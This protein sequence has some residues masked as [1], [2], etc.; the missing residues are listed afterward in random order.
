MTSIN[1]CKRPGF[2]HQAL[3]DEIAEGARGGAA[4]TRSSLP[5]TAR[6][7]MPCSAPAMATDGVAA[8]APAPAP[9]P[10]PAQQ[11]RPS[12]SA[13]R[14]A[15]IPFRQRHACRG[16]LMVEQHRPEPRLRLDEIEIGVDERLGAAR[17]WGAGGLAQR[18][19]ETG[20]RLAVQRQDQPV[21]IVVEIVERARR[22]AIRSATARTVTPLRPSAQQRFRARLPAPCGEA[23]PGD[24]RCGVPNLD[25]LAAERFAGPLPNSW[26]GARPLLSE[27]SGGCRYRARPGNPDSLRS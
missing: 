15:P 5:E 24:D 2:H 20:Q 21:E 6:V 22:I 4:V 26:P 9:W 10:A 7:E 23:R 1:T 8:R 3:D 13:A 19:G 11:W 14:A 25:L 18:G 16:R 27:P 17:H 12:T